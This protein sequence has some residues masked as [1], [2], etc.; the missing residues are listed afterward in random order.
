MRLLQAFVVAGFLGAQGLALAEDLACPSLQL[1]QIDWQ[2]G[3][4]EALEAAKKSMAAAGFKVTG[5][6][7]TAVVGQMDKPVAQGFIMLQ[8]KTASV[9]SLVM[10][11]V[12]PAPMEALSHAQDLRSHMEKTPSAGRQV[13][14]SY[15][16]IWVQ[17]GDGTAALKPWTKTFS[18]TWHGPP[19][20]ADG[21]VA[22]GL[23]DMGFQNI[24]GGGINPAHSGIKPHEQLTAVVT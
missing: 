11:C 14:G 13:K 1:M 24:Q 20:A 15:S 9:T 4:K 18:F 21:A 2:G 22:Q 19:E 17:E 6:N 10:V 7:A 12:A 23:R 5:T 16:A 8:A 3:D